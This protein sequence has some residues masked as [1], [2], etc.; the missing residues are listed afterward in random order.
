[1][2]RL[3][4]FALLTLAVTT[5]FAAAELTANADLCIP[6]AVVQALS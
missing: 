4:T 6:A 2:K 5:P 3:L 1:M